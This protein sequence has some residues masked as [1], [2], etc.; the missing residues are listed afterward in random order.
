MEKAFVLPPIS[1]RKAAAR[2]ALVDLS[3]ASRTLLAECFRQFGIETVAM[4]GESGDRLHKE[5]F[6]ACV[7]SLKDDSAQLME[8]A[9]TLTDVSGVGLQ[10]PDA[11]W[12]TNANDWFIGETYQFI[13]W[14][15]TAGHSD[16]VGPLINDD[17]KT[18]QLTP[19]DL[20]NLK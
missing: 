13:K 17:G 15:A 19:G 11:K 16:S 12:N 10:L 6:E 7:L 14:N 9:R 20:I 4:S 8:A 18:A 1:P 2:A 3:N 5:K